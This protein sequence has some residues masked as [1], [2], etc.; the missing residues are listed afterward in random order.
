M[1]GSFIQELKRRNV[2][3]VAIIYIVVSWLL[4]QI[5]DVMFP[6]L[7]LPEW[8]TTLLVAFLILGFP[9]AIIFAWAFELTP[10]GVVRTDEVP[11]GQSITSDTG[12][13]INYLI[14]GILIV[15]VGFLLVKDALRTES[16]IQPVISVADQS[17]A[18]LPFKNQSASE[19]NAAF[20]AGGLHDELLTLLS[21]L[22]DLKVISRT[23]VERLD[24]NLS[25][26][27]IGELLGVATVLEGQVQRAGDRLR[28]N[29]QLIDTAE[30]GHVWANT[31]NSELTAEN[32]F[33]VQSDIARTI[34]GALQAELSPD[35]EQELSA[36]PTTNTR[37]FEKYLLAMQTAKPG[38]YEAMQLA[39]SYLEEVVTLD[40]GFAEAWVGLAQVRSELFQTGAIGRDEFVS[41]AG[42]TIETALSL[43]PRNGD[44]HAVRAR[45]QDAAGRPDAA[46]ASFK[47]ALR[48]SPRSSLVRE[49]YGDFLRVNGRYEEARRI[50]RKGLEFDPLS[51]V[52]MFELGRVEMY[53]G[54]PEANIEAGNRILEL[55]PA[56]VRGYVALLQA[57]IWRGHFD[58]A[59]PWYVKTIEIDSGDF[60][61]WAHAAVYL[62]DLGAEELANRYIE[63]AESF[64]AGEPVV[65]KSRIQLQSV[66]EQTDEALK[67]A[68]S[69]MND[70]FGNRWG[71][72]EV[73]LRTIG[74]AAVQDGS[75]DDVIDMYRRWHP[76]LFLTVPEISPD[77]IA[78][79]ANLAWLLQQAGSP[80]RA[81]EIIDAAL[82]WYRR[83][84]PEGVHG[85]NLGIVDVRLLALAGE[86]ELA[87]ETLRDAVDSGWRMGWQW[88]MSNPALDGIRSTP[89][90]QQIVTN[91][92]NAMALQLE[93]IMA[94]PHL[95]EFDLRDKPAE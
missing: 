58:E 61:T 67:L 79:A 13:K 14:I 74:T 38:T 87:L 55:D 71:S 5:G 50:L 47:Q 39:E 20:F 57:N 75:Y 59:W 1:S 48:L 37:A 31:Y 70:E 28:I 32:V 46:E 73:L 91:I 22:G 21:K 3:R 93:N 64:G 30:E 78:I 86:T 56:S 69:N 42:P 90:F 51:L 41:T 68:K 45:V 7:R 24:P 60:E 23:S 6:A 84:Q 65:V 15:A 53:L 77:N 40:P 17:I 25:I 4:M 52:I 36:V 44:A 88:R 8:T 12:Q 76:K 2:F 85:Y 26:P 34:A 72:H 10:D 11:E 54:N 89:E 95:G 66:R 16:P 43:D 9:V 94:S 18:V 92:E 63:H 19:E 80:H 83:T 35:D 29:V 27:E 49:F 81:T 62:D 33:E 82:N